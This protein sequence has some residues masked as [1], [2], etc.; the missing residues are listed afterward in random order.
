MDRVTFTT[1]VLMGRSWFSQLLEVLLDVNESRHIAANF[2]VDLGSAMDDPLPLESVPDLEFS[3]SPSPS[4]ADAVND[5]KWRLSRDQ[6]SRAKSRHARSVATLLQHHQAND[7]KPLGALL[8]LPHSRSLAEAE[9]FLPDELRGDP[10][11]PAYLTPVQENEYLDALDDALS[12]SPSKRRLKAS[13]HLTASVIEREEDKEMALKNPVSVYNWLKRNRA[14]TFRGGE[15]G[16]GTGAGAAEKTGAKSSRGGAGKRAGT[17]AASIVTN[18]AGSDDEAGDDAEHLASD[19][20]APTMTLSTSK[21]A[22]R[23]KP[24][25]ATE[26]HEGSATRVRAGSSKRVSATNASKNM[27]ESTVFT[28]GD[29]SVYP[30]LELSPP[31]PLSKGKRKRDDDGGYRP[32]GGSSGGSRST[33]K[34]KGGESKAPSKAVAPRKTIATT[35]TAASTSALE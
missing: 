13:L 16:A 8:R 12:D 9:P 7:P 33:K 27:T 11:P 25:R 10:N 28:D 26:G 20:G 34:Q 29:G 2:R 23:N 35:T 24:R 5:G 19:A 14:N 17:V 3:R 18:P 6:Q 22:V 31:P 32:K 21:A 30:Q 1:L 4:K 15:E